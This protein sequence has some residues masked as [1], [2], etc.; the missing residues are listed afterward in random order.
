MERPPS[1]PTH[2]GVVR[3]PTHASLSRREALRRWALGGAG[4]GAGWSA[5][6]AQ[7]QAASAS[8]KNAGATSTR[9][10][11]SA[12]RLEP[13]PEVA[14]RRSDPEAYWTRVRRGQFLL[15]ET[16]AFL[17]PGSL[18]VMPRPVMQA[19]VESLQRG[20]EYATDTVQRWGYESMEP[21]RAEMA[22][23]LG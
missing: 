19:V 12:S 14:L 10:T 8:A 21:E 7:A 3:P 18:G 20:A 15:P 4:I 6:R 16:R 17:N 5:Q 23:F 22:A 13:L 2:P 11:A 1:E 9:N